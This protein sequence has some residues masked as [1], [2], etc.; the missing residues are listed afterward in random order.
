[1]TTLFHPVNQEPY[2]VASHQVEL[3]LNR[4]YSFEPELLSNTRNNTPLQ[5][6]VNLNT[7]SFRDLAQRLQLT[8]SIG[9]AIMSSRPFSDTADLI[10]R[11]Q[12]P[13]YHYECIVAQIIFN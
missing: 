13:S 2:E 3:F 7:C 10:S 9:L 1:M 5:Q 12:I 4:G 6:L 8:P 11:V